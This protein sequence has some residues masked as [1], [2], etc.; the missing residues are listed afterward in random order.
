MI[1]RIFLLGRLTNW[2][3]PKT[4]AG[5]GDG[6]GALADSAAGSSP[7]PSSDLSL[8]LH[9]TT[10][11]PR[12]TFAGDL[13]HDRQSLDVHVIGR[14]AELAQ[15]VLEPGQLLWV[16][17]HLESDPAVRE[18]APS[19]D[20]DS[21]PATV[22]GGLRIVASRFT[23]LASAEASRHLDGVA[24][25]DSPFPFSG[26]AREGRAEGFGAESGTQSGAVGGAP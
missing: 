25:D 11:A 8:L 13:V 21:G 9:L 7:S 10:F 14:V 3:T 15:L 16:D 20:T 23:I 6:H 12:L 18:S 1:N 5:R 4:P 26:S 17:A 2:P 19:R 22:S 24:D